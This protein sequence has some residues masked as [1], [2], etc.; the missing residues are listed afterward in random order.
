MGIR[1]GKSA[2][3]DK[4][5]V[6]RPKSPCHRHIAA[7]TVS[8][9]GSASCRTD[10]IQKHCRLPEAGA[11]TRNLHTASLK[12]DIHIKARCE[13]YP[14]TKDVLRYKVPDDKVPWSVDFP[15]YNPIEYTAEGILKQP[16][17][18]DPPDPRYVYMYSALVVCRPYKLSK[19]LTS[20][21]NIFINIHV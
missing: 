8:S 4:G 1:L 19:G 21:I 3:V 17:W 2:C 15:E 7:L 20:E 18:A 12:M 6:L 5:N 16:V 11:H 13:V 14:R 9:G 10:S